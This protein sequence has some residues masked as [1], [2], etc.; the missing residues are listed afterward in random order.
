MRAGVRK[1]RRLF[2]YDGVLDEVE[3]FA[4]SAGEDS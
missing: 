4:K 1:Y 2:T 3:L